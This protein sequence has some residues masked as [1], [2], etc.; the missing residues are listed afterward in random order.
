MRILIGIATM[1]SGGAERQVADLVEGVTKISSLNFSTAR[2]SQVATL[3]KMI[4]AMASD[5]RVVLMRGG[6]NYSR[7]VDSGASITFIAR[8]RVRLVLPVTPV[9]KRIQP[10]VVYMWQRPFDV[11]GGLAALVLGIPCVHAE[12]TAPDRVPSSAHVTMRR[13]V[14]RLSSGVIANSEAG[15]AH[16]RAYLRPSAMVERIDNMVPQEELSRVA[17]APES[18]RALVVVGRLDEGKNVMTL[19]RAVARLQREGVPCPVMVIGEGPLQGRLSEFIHANSLQS[20]VTLCGFRSDAWA[21]MK[22]SRAVVSLSRFEGSPNAVLEAEALGVPLLLSD[23]PSHRSITSRAHFVDPTSD[24]DVA[25]ALR[26]VC[27]AEADAHRL[28]P[29]CRSSEN[30]TS[31]PNVIEQHLDV[32]RRAVLGRRAG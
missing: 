17:P 22:G 4:L 23:I 15:A 13:A 16:W 7:L 10:D 5:V 6:A 30:D 19:I 12:R 1:E 21:L 31:R 11:I 29:Y 24:E 18:A 25:T 32:F 2:E 9:F 14:V 3:R 26:R 20:M 8:T 28:S 27:G